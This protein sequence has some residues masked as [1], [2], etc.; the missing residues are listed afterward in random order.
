MSTK[1]PA[2][3]VQ[4]HPV[5]SHEEWLEARKALLAKEKQFTRLR[6]ELSQDRRR[7]PWERVDKE[8]VF[9]GP[10]GSRALA[11]LF[12]DCHQLVDFNLIPAHLRARDISFIAISRAPINQ[13]EAYRKRMAWSF[14]W[15]SSFGNDF[16]YD[17]HVSF[18]PEELKNS[19]AFHN[20]R[21][22]DMEGLTDDQGVSVFY[23]TA[24]IGTQQGR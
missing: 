18:T 4:H 24:L 13:L 15:F 10:D 17:Y 9:E 2:Y 12:G 14:P 5:T 1:A 11:D 16:N 6:D 7:L 23:K 20:Y 19:R 21:F 3:D 22:G 8:Y